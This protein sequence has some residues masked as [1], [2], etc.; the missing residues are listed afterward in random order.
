M[1]QRTH[2]CLIPWTALDNYSR[3]ENA[4]TGADRDYR[5]EDIKNILAIPTLIR[6]N[7]ENAS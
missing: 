1:E 5:Y 2:A 3:K 4:I 6:R 7:K